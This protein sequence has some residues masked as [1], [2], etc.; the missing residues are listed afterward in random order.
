MKDLLGR[1]S[2]VTRQSIQ[3]G[4]DAVFERPGDLGVSLAMLVMHDGQVVAERYGVSPENI[5]EPA[6]Q[7]TA[8]S[9]LISWST[10]K[11]IAHAA[12]GVLVHDGVLDVEGPAA[13][14]EWAGTPKAAITLLDLLEMR[15]GLR[16]VED[17]VDDGI[18]H[19][20]AMLFG[21]GAHDQAAYAS[22][23]PLDHAPGSVWSYSSGTTN[24]ISRIL[25]DA[26][27]GGRSGMEGFLRDRLFGP[28]GMSSAVPEFD[29]VGTWVASSYV[30]ATA[31]DFARFGEL[32]RNDG[33]T[34]TGVRILPVGWADHGRTKVAHDPEAAMT[35]GLDYGR[36]WWMWPKYP[37]SIAAHGHEGQYIVV[38]PDRRLTLVHLGKTDAAVVGALLSMLDALVASVPVGPS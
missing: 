31:A 34:T 29:E 38:V 8:A 15:S 14:P 21:E 22:A 23:L 18:S 5:F 12:V 11:S 10:A 17:Y 37:G 13:V 35:G 19:C 3:A 24:I 1:D 25:G 33:V 2:D 36:H 7:I 32:Y 9:R 6:R 26:V 16:F 4:V 28:A 20:I 30:Y 27:G